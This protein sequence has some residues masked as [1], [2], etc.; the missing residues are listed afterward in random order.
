MPLT[1]EQ[2]GEMLGLTGVH[3]S[4]TLRQ[5]RDEGLIV[6]EGHRVEITNF[7]ALSSLEDFD[8][9]HSR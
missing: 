6:M 8:G 4:R 9:A 5:L 7:E 3:I 2:I 1:Q